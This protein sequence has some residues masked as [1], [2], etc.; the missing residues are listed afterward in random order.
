M[1]NRTRAN[2][3]RCTTGSIGGTAMR[4]IEAE[5][6]IIPGRISTATWAGIRPRNPGPASFARPARPCGTP[7]SDS[8]RKGIC[9]AMIGKQAAEVTSPVSTSTFR[10]CRHPGHESGD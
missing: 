4:R 5:S 2:P 7:D 6:R 3:I 1:P 9:A 10:I 8:S